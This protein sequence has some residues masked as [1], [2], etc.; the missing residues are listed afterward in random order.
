[1]ARTDPDK[2]LSI[3][4]ATW[5]IAKRAKK[6]VSAAAVLKAARRVGV[7]HEDNTIAPDV[8]EAMVRRYVA[9]GYYFPRLY[10]QGDGDAA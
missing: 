2:N 4:E 3:V 10:R 1:M 6:P 7:L 5:L 9:S 8:V